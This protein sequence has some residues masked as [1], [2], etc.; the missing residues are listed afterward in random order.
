MAAFNLGIVFIGA[1]AG[2]KATIKKIYSASRRSIKIKTKRKPKKS[3][4]DSSDMGELNIEHLGNHFS[5]KE[6]LEL[7][8]WW[9]KEEYGSESGSEN[10]ILNEIIQ[11]DEENI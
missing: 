11:E 9:V 3:L 5:T 10:E 1:L 7:F 4:D 8:Q 6:E 2:I